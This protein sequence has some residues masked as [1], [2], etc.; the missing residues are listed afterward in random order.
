ME[1]IGCEY[2]GSNNHQNLAI[3][4]FRKEVDDFFAF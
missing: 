2:I 3:D 4:N 1:I